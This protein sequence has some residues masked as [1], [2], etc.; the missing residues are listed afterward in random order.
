MFVLRRVKQ[1]KYVFSLIPLTVVLL[2]WACKLLEWA[3][4]CYATLLSN[5]NL[6]VCFVWTYILSVSS[7]CLHAF[8]CFTKLKIHKSISIV[9]LLSFTLFHIVMVSTVVNTFGV[10]RMYT[11]LIIVLSWYQ[12]VYCF[13]LVCSVLCCSSSIASNLTRCAV[14][15]AI[16][17]RHLPVLIVCCLP[18]FICQIY[19]EYGTH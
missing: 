5:N 18:A 19:N 11:R 2:Y 16:R 12:C 7:I 17:D 4:T 10:L 14:Q 9:L 6:D 15:T 1:Q 8:S 3:T 13:H